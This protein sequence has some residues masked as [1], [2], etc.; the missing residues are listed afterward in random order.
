MAIDKQA[1]I[2]VV[3]QGSGQ[4]AKNPI[5][6][7][8]WS[9][10]DAV[11][12]DPYDPEAAKKMLEEEGVTD[13]SMKIWAM[14]VQRPYNPNARRMAELIQ[15][16][17]AEVGVDVEIVSYEWGEYLE[18][19]KALDRD[20]A[21]LLGWTGDNGDPDNFL[22][23]LLGC[24]AVGASEPRAVVLRAV[25]R[26]DPGSQDAD[27]PGRARR[28]LRGGAGRLQGAGALGHHRALGR[29]HADAARSGRLQGAPAGRPHLHRSEPRRIRQSQTG[30]GRP[31]PALLLGRTSMDRFAQYRDVARRARRRRRRRSCPGRT[32]PARSARPFTP[33]NAPL[34]DRSPPRARRPPSCPT[35]S[36]A[37]GSSSAFEGEVFD[38]RDQAG[39]DGAFAALAGHLPLSSLAVEG[40]VMRVFV[41]HA[42]SRA[43]PGLRSST[44]EREISGLRTVKT[45][46]EVAALERAIRH[47]RSRAGRDAGSG[48]RRP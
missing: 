48:A 36:C 29:L 14:P 20:G 11:E 21:V 24:D 41:H 43:Y 37:P 39:Y 44:R 31:G 45:A 33:T 17:F 38:W 47:F 4:I 27:R 22:A 28:A 46:A 8:M 10:N 42:L 18:R 12:D 25:R 40:Q 35:S 3:F 30:A 26:P 9:Y 34:V 7:T 15:E 23:V 6:P 2:D 16:D 19:S 5:P 13:L 1:I 32:S